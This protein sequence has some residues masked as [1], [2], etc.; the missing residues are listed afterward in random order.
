MKI[1]EIG[2][3]LPLTTSKGSSDDSSTPSEYAKI[4][5]EKIADARTEM[6]QMDE[7]QARLDEIAELHEELTG[8]ALGSSQS[9]EKSTIRKFKPDGSIL[10][11]T[12]QDG[13]TVSVIKKKP[14][15]VAVSDPMAPPTPSGKIA[16]KLEARPEIDFAAF[17]M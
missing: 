14:R 6:E 10:F 1:W 5:A 13:K 16:I 12:V 3:Q 4:L 8:R 7:I 11:L 9:G 15:L 17:M 2:S